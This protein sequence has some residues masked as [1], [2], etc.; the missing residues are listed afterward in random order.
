LYTKLKEIP[1]RAIGRW[2]KCT[3]AIVHSILIAL[4]KGDQNSNN[5]DG[6]KAAIRNAGVNLCP[7]N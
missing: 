6:E 3:T 1:G 2:L 4:V 5:N 7:Y